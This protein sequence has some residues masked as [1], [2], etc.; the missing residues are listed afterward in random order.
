MKAIALVS[1]GL[2]SILAAKLVQEL[3]IE[4]IAFHFVI[5]FCHRSKK[6]S[7]E[8]GRVL[9]FVRDNLGVPLSKIDVKDIFL[10]IIKKPAH[11]FGSNMNPCIDCKI[12]MLRKAKEMMAELDAKFIITG[13]VLGQRPMSQHRQALLTIAKDSGLEG[14][15]LRPLSAKLLEET[16]PE[17]EGWISRDKL[18]NFG[19]RGRSDQ[20]KLAKDL[21]IKDFAQPAGGCLLTDPLFTKRLKELIKHGELDLDNIELLKVGRHF[22][23]SADAKLVVGRDEGEN[24]ELMSL[25]KDGDYL[26]MPTE[27]MAGP[28][29][30]GRGGFNDELIKFSCAITCRYCDTDS[31][32]GTDI[33]WFGNKDAR[34]NH[35]KALPAKDKE[36]VSFRI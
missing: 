28:T 32:G 26:F 8:G 16:I 34:K 11:G 18:L 7:P 27:E 9:E 4:V 23:L 19:G 2:D 20:V 14:L 17:K 13:E 24:E 31:L 10:E 15:V 6:N 36:F 25:A 30:L 1:G 35:L 3:G 12:L 33:I 5:P 22:R 21:D 29:S